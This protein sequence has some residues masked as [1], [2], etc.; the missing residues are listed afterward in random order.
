LIH[1]INDRDIGERPEYGGGVPRLWRELGTESAPPGA[2][3]EFLDHSEGLP[4]M[5][6]GL[7]S[8]E[9]GGAR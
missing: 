5:G 7:I 1:G 6:I 8:Q 3:V 2:M 4:F 9:D